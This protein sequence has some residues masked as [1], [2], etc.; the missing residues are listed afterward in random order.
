VF[1]FVTGDVVD[2]ATGASLFGVQ[3]TAQ[4]S[5]LNLRC[6]GI[7]CFDMVYIFP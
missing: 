7:F 6:L 1:V 2:Y 4:T 3:S 5:G